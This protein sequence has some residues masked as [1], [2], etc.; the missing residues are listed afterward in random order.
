M[1]TTQTHSTT[2]DKRSTKKKQQS[3]PDMNIGNPKVAL[4]KCKHPQQEH[5]LLSD[6][7]HAS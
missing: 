4:R 3:F 2:K 6:W 5:E 1:T 7:N